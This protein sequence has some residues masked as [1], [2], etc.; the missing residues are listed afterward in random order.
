MNN[1][2]ISGK[3]VDMLRRRGAKGA[4]IAPDYNYVKAGLVDSLG[5]LR[6]V[7]ELE[8][9]FGIEFN[10]AEVASNEFKT[11]GGLCDLIERKRS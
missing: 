8:E 4:L 10:N 11:L 5:L 6:F 1:M 2:Y 3:V 7:L 9:F